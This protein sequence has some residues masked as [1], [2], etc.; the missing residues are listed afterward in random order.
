MISNL[1]LIKDWCDANINSVAWQ[2]IGL[3]LF[4][5]LSNEGIDFDQIDNP[6]ASDEVSEKVFEAINEKIKAIYQKSI[7]RKTVEI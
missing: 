4:D 3:E 7:D 5:E 6:T 1:K 2:R